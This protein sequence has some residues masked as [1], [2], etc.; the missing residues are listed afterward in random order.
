[1]FEQPGH[2][3]RSSGGTQRGS[4]SAGEPSRVPRDD[5]GDAGLNSDEP[6][7]FVLGGNGSTLAFTSSFR[8]QG[9]AV[10]ARLVPLAWTPAGVVLGDS[11]QNV[12]I[13]LR[14]LVDWADRTFPPEDERAFL[15]PVRDIELLARSQWS[16]QLP[17][18]LDE[19]I[20]LNIEDLP[21]DVAEAL[22]HPAASIVQC[23][24]CRRLCV[25]DDFVWKERQLCAWDYHTQVFGKRGP[26]R[27]GAY[28]EHHYDSLASCAYVAPTLLDELGVQIAMALD[29][30]EEPTA[31]RLV[32]LLLAADT[33]RAHLAVRT[34]IGLHVLAEDAA[35]PR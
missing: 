5:A 21:D 9:G 11:W 25:K 15:A 12:G 4:G 22:A 19:E 20:V 13:A 33:G 27:E 7:A 28:E 2:G 10:T 30:V 24:A 3:E 32:E 8:P 14:G 18:Q 1:M 34:K 23:S 26:W 29:G 17:T 6:A 16:A 35:T 31:R